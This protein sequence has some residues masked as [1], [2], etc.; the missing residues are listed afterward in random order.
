M[1]APCRFDFFKPA[2]VLE[3]VGG[4]GV[5][6]PSSFT[7]ADRIEALGLRAERGSFPTDTPGPTRSFCAGR[8]T[9]FKISQSIA[10]TITSL[11]D[12]AV[13]FLWTW[14]PSPFTFQEL[15]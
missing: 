12:Q 14:L 5:R 9:M 15:F 6:G 4:Q 13:F 7:R 11:L 1:A 3:R 10:L 8:R 2:W